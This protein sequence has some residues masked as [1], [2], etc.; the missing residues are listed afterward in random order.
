MLIVACTGYQ[1]HTPLQKPIVEMSTDLITQK[2]CVSCILQAGNC[3]LYSGI[4]TSFE[5]WHA[6][7]VPTLQKTYL[8]RKTQSPQSGQLGWH[9]RKKAHMS[10]S[11]GTSW[12]LSSDV[13]TG[14]RESAGY[15][16]GWV[17]SHK[18][19]EGN[20]RSWT[21]PGNH[22][23]SERCPATRNRPHHLYELKIYFSGG[24]GAS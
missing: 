8:S 21:H 17:E 15:W 1:L 20:N 13:K 16:P 2:I 10:S 23:C 12:T 18:N 24:D 7:P 5:L 6:M 9:C 3:C 19:W 14:R 22:L 4:C 11:A